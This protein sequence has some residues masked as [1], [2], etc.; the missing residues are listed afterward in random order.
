MHYIVR[1][2][3]ARSFVYTSDDDEKNEKFINFLKKDNKNRKR[4]KIY[5]KI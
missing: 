2:M 1:N 5:I 3:R 4:N